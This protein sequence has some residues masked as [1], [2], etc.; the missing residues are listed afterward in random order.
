MTNR[1]Y[2][3][4]WCNDFSEATMLDRYGN[5]LGTVPF[6]A[7]RP[8]FERLIIR[9]VDATES[10]LF[11]HDLRAVPLDAERVVEMSRQ[12]VHDDSA[13]EALAYWDLWTYN[14]E[15]SQWISEP[16]PLEIFCCGPAYDNGVGQE[17][18]NLHADLGFEQFFTGYSGLVGL[19]AIPA[20]LPE[21]IADGAFLAEL[22]KPARLDEYQDKTRQNIRTLTEWVE[23]IESK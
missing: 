22:A 5:L 19:R 20:E 13:F 18:G 17:F 8:G 23:R 9:A 15:R 1:A 16:Q 2:L 21:D 14:A 4:V 3:S 11:E 12:G 6:S 10:P 7:T